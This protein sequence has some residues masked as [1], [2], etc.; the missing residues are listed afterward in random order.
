MNKKT[1]SVSSTNPAISS[2]CVDCVH[3][4]VC[5]YRT[6]MQALRDEIELILAKEVSADARKL[7]Y[8]ISYTCRYRLN[9]T[10]ALTR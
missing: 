4:G 10:I 6:E 2:P 1:E 8:E 5:K 3:S 9:P 7:I